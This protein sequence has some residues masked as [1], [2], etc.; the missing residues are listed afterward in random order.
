M[1]RYYKYDECISKTYYNCVPNTISE[2]QGNET[3]YRRYGLRPR[4]HFKVLRVLFSLTFAMYGGL[5]TTC[6]A[7]GILSQPVT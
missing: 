7:A 3:C 2:L 6:M 1:S 4:E 5:S